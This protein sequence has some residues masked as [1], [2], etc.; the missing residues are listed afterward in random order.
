MP[1]IIF[2]LCVLIAIVS[3]AMAAES[4]W[5][6]WLG[7]NRDGKSLDTGLLKQ[8]PAE[9]PTLL[10]KIDGIGV[11]FSSVAVTGGKVYITGDR[12]GKLTISAFNLDGKLLWNAEHGQG[13]GGPDGSRSTPV[14][15]DRNLYLLSG[16]GQIGCYDTASG[17][18]KWSHTAK[19][20]GGSP[21]GWG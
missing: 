20:F 16:H 12:D 11:G 2:S 5:P 19:E 14:I 13:R 4:Y 15:D 9:G 21:G 8:W 3:S 7:P 18:Q 10:W 6:G 17:Q 1:R